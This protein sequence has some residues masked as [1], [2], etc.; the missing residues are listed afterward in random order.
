MLT[1]Q[2]TATKPLRTRA[3]LMSQVAYAALNTDTE[4]NPCVWLN[5][6]ACGCGHEWSDDWSC[7]CDDECGQCGKDS[8]PHDSDWLGPVEAAAQ[9]LWENLPEA[10]SPEALTLAGAAQ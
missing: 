9:A 4:G 10:G 3:D 7:Q 2:T 1:A 6:Y 5:H 8:S